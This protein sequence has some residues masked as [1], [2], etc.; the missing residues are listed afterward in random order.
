MK[1]TAAKVKQN[2]SSLHQSLVDQLTQSGAG[3]IGRVQNPLVQ[4][5]AW[6]G[7]TGLIMG[8]LIAGLKPRP[9][10]AE[11]FQ[12][13][14]FVLFVGFILLASAFSAWGAVLSGIPG[15]GLALW[16]KIFL[17]AALIGLVLVPWFLFP[18]AAADV[19]S[20]NLD[21]DYCFPLVLAI[22]LL[23]WV[24]LGLTLSK[25][26]SFRPAV[27]GLWSGTSAF[28]MASGALFVCC[29]CWTR[30]HLLTAH[31]LPVAVASFATALLGSYWFSRWNKSIK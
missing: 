12:N 17:G 10:M 22:G 20:G 31:V 26:A 19:D 5:L 3:S 27:T 15:R 29:P 6:L 28:L 1:S 21:D 4:W 23:P 14:G 30:S 11:N 2:P 13:P 8:G 18:A 16:Q 9:D 25:N 24:I 7:L